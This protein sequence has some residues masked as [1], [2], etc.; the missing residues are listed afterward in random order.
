MEQDVHMKNIW[1]DRVILSPS[2]IS[3][4]DLCRLADSVRCL[5]ESGTKSLHV[6]II[7]GHFSPSMPIGLDTVRQL[8]KLSSLV[9]DVHVMTSQNDFFV[10][11]LIDIGVD[12]IVFHG[13]TE[14]HLDYRLNR[15][16][17][18]GIRAGI[19]L[20]P[21]TSLS[22]LDYVLDKCDAVLLMLI[23]PGYAQSKSEGQVPYATRKIKQLHQMISERGLSTRV[24]LDGRISKENLASYVP[25]CLADTFVLG[26]T[27]LDKA[28][29]GESIKQ[30]DQF[31]R[32]L[33]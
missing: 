11:E 12:Q 19:A 31:V 21:G 5:E 8:K 20:K 16:H 32:S 1:Q 4:C 9:F 18:A 2:L 22:T 24:I 13:E 33:S 25:D 23:N 26:S 14:T 27:C 17:D 7:D 3:C 30:I 10:D 28:N 29:L 15:I 6:D